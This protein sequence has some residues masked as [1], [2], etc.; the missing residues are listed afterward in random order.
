[1]GTFQKLT[2]RVLQEESSNLYDS[3]LMSVD[4]ATLDV[5]EKRAYDDLVKQN[6][7]VGALKM[8][9][10]SVEGD[11]SQLSPELQ[12]AAKEYSDWSE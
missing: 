3:V 7:K 11:L 5:L 9:V 10:N 8:I 4:L 2:E 6:G 1:M 12:H